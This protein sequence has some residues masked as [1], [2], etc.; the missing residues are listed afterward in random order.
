MAFGWLRSVPD[1]VIGIS[2]SRISQPR[3]ADSCRSH[4]WHGRG[5]LSALVW[6]KFGP[7]GLARS[8]L[9]QSSPVQPSHGQDHLYG[10]LSIR[11][12]SPT[13]PE[14]MPVAKRIRHQ[15]R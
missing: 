9:A 14:G 10:V 8:N 13:V 7:P 12:A 3:C 5:P 1:L 2:P 11:D 15:T 4:A 6:G